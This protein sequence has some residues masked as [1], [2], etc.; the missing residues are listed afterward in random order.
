MDRLAVKRDPLLI[1]LH[2]NALVR[3]MDPFHVGRCQLDGR[4]AVVVAIKPD[5]SLL[6]SK[7]RQGSESEVIQVQSK[8]DRKAQS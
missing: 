2:P 7:E 8:L 4:E 3:T 5:T 1:I 6:Y